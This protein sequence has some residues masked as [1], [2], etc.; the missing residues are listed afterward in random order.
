M[1]TAT[2]DTATQEKTIAM[3]Q[4]AYRMELETVTNY[5]SNSVH[6]DGVAA[7]EIKRSLGGDVTEELGHARRLASRI[8]QLGGRIPG[9]LELQ[10]DQ[11]SLRPPEKTTNVLA[12]VSGVIEAEQ[13]AIDHYQDIIRHSEEI[14]DPVTADLATTI[15]A[16]E[17][18]HRTQFVGFQSSLKE[19]S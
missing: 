13:S 7:E 5:L 19:S 4:K 11:E 6:L 17:F 14:G 10:F 2:H 12:V 18:E 9:S 16:D 3:L 8:K 1:A 15:L